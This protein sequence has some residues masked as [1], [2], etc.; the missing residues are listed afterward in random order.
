MEVFQGNRGILTHREGKGMLLDGNL[1][2]EQERHRATSTSIQFSPMTT[3]VATPAIRLRLTNLPLFDFD[4]L[5]RGLRSSLNP[6][7]VVLDVGF[8]YSPKTQAY[9]TWGHG[10][11]VTEMAHLD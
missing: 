11:A 10:I 5:E 3:I 6:S 8:T 1:K 4:D 9:C 2:T 7:A